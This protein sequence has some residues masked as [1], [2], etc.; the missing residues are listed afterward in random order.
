M[1][2]S[3]RSGS[4]V[5]FG[6][7][8][9]LDGLSFAVRRGQVCGL[10]GPNGAGKTTLFNCV[11]RLYT[12]QPRRDRVR[13]RGP[14]RRARRTRSP[15]SASRAPSR[16]SGC[17]Q[18]LTVRENVMLGRAT[19]AARRA[20]CRRALRL[21]GERAR[22]ARRCASEADELLERLEPGRRRRPTGR[23]ASRTARSSASSWR[24]RCAAARAC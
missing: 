11:S 7:V 1:S 24:A 19:S 15:R 9:A 17:S 20:S 13:R 5:R 18:S 10:I 12:P 2:I 14:A 6:G 22:G 8:T 21:P 4:D 3:G 23:R 16:T